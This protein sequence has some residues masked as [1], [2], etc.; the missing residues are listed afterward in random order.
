MISLSS[1]EEGEGEGEGAALG[2]IGRRYWRTT[3]IIT[4]Y[5]LGL[6]LI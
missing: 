3:Q 1:K 4:A 5:M 6:N 2:F